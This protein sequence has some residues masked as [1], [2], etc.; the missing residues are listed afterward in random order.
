VVSAPEAFPEASPEASVLRSLPHPAERRTIMRRARMD[1]DGCRADSEKVMAA[2]ESWRV[3][4]R[5]HIILSVTIS[6][7]PGC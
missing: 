1:V 2:V 5:I 4:I 3:I 7:A 6:G